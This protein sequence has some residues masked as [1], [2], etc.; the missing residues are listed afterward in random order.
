MGQEECC[1]YHL[2]RLFQVPAGCILC[3]QLQIVAT[4]M[5][6]HDWA[7]WN[8]LEDHS[9]LQDDHVIGQRFK[10]FLLLNIS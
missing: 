1:K 3:E 9:V 10:H 8:G 4:N 5:F 6:F 7:L 2:D